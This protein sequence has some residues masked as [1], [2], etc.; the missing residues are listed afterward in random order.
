MERKNLHEEATDS[1]SEETFERKGD[2]IDILLNKEDKEPIVL[3][4]E[5]G[6]KLAFEQIAVIPYNDKIYVVL[7]PIDKIE[8]IE[9]NEA[10]VFYVDE[11]E[12]KEPGL[13]VE[14]NREIAEK[15]F[16]EYLDLLDENKQG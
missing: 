9:E 16:D 15:I 10:I 14:T 6:E 1:I 11:V 8:H 5:N 2:L 7:K 3:Q 4:D 13:R 12:G